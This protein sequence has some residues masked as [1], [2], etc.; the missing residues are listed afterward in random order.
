MLIRHLPHEKNIEKHTVI[1]RQ[2]VKNADVEGLMKKIKVYDLPIRIFHWLFAGLFLGAFII[3]KVLDDESPTYPVHM[4]MGIT[5]ALIIILRL[6]W[7]FVGSRYAKFTS[8]ALNPTKLLLYVRQLFTGKTTRTHGHNPASSWAALVMML[9]ALGLAVTGYL[10]ASGGD[11]RSLKEIHELLANAFIIIAVLHVAG[12]VFHSMRHKDWIGLSM[13]NGKK[14]EVPGEVG[15]QESHIGVALLFLVI[16]S[17]FVFQLIRNYDFS[18]Q[19][20][21]FFG[22]TLQLGEVENEE[23]HKKELEKYNHHENN[24]DEDE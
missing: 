16:T 18:S 12:V 4:L 24:D 21:L 8:F 15:I 22:S 1:E 11:K 23:H 5:L 14:L 7:G 20:L 6:I 3:A 9:L 13:I 19:Q 10:M 17:A 2:K